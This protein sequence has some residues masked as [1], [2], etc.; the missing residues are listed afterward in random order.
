[1]KER[2]RKERISSLKAETK[3]TPPNIAGRYLM[4]K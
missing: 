4:S 1:M 3:C 2:R